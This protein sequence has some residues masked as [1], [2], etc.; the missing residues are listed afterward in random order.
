MPAAASIDDARRQLGYERLRSG[1]REAV[2]AVLAGRD[3]L[4]V[5]PT[6]SGKSAIY[7]LAGA[8][9]GGPTVVVSPLLALQRD[10]VEALE[11]HDAA[12][13]PRSTRCSRAASARRHSRSWRSDELEFVFLAP[14][15]LAHEE[16]VER[17]A[18][19]RP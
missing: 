6:G 3:T 2:E 5:M 8:A 12:R 11:E 10:Q 14:E 13:R 18:A 15:Q 4:A 17:L 9:D 7:Q 16:T 19:A 1:Q